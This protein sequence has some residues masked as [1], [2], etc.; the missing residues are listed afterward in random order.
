M[1]R[2]LRR[3]FFARKKKKSPPENT[4]SA[5][6]LPPA[7]SAASGSCSSIW[8]SVPDALAPSEPVEQGKARYLSFDKFK[9]LPLE[10]QQMILARLT[11]VEW[12]PVAHIHP[13][14]KALILAMPK[15]YVS[16][17]SWCNVDPELD[18]E[19][20]LAKRWFEGGRQPGPYP[21][22][23]A[24]L[25][26]EFYGGNV[27]TFRQEM[28]QLGA[29]SYVANIHPDCRLESALL[30]IRELADVPL[31]RLDLGIGHSTAEIWA[32]RNV[33]VPV[34][35]IRHEE[36]RSKSSGEIAQRAV[37]HQVLPV[38][39]QMLAEMIRQW[40]AGEREIDAIEFFLEGS[41]R[42]ELGLLT[43]MVQSLT[44]G[45]DSVKLGSHNTLIRRRLD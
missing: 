13:H 28:E 22:Q 12:L 42:P 5:S 32:L 37:V 7:F 27:E 1:L 21:G 9:A 31:K 30:L 33:K 26:A 14:F 41:S 17:A 38:I 34:M 6:T 4:V 15:R 29:H 39:R 19:E 44:V 18:E 20:N 43:A 45:E 40:R 36:V 24:D 8:S 2:T 11:P 35:Q 3:F 10:L 25:Y 16:V 23:K